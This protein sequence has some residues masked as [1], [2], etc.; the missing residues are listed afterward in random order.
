MELN[1]LRSAS[2]VLL[3]LIFV[4]IVVWAYSRQRQSAFDAAAQLPLIDDTP[5]PSVRPE[6]DK[7]E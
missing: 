6:E 3:L 5:T 4:G 2:T 7:H 1:A